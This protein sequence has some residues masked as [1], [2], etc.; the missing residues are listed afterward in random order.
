M[1]MVVY[2]EEKKKSIERWAALGDDI[3]RMRA[4]GDFVTDSILMYP[5]FDMRIHGLDRTEL[6]NGQIPHEWTRYAVIDPGHTVTAVLFAA[7]L[8]NTTRSI[9]EFDPNLFAPC[10]DTHAAS[11]IAINPG[12]VFSDPFT[13]NTS[14][15]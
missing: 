15:L 9:N 6:P 3:L 12:T 4:E 8:P 10:T 14:A 11:P 1:T 5:N 7:D 13:V 2:Q